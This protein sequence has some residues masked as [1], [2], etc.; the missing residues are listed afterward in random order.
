[1]EY[2]E[3]LLM[4]DVHLPIKFLLYRFCFLGYYAS[5]IML[6]LFKFKLLKLHYSS[7]VENILL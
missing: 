5:F 2:L 4:T 1:M 3:Q 6:V 7:N